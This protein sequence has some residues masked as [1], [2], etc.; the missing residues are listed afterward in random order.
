MGAMFTRGA[1][2]FALVLMMAGSASAAT[3]VAT[4]ADAGSSVSV[5]AGDTLLVKLRGSW[6]MASDLTP[7]LV[8]DSQSDTGKG[9]GARSSFTF[10]AD[11]AGSATLVV[12]N[13]ITKH[14]LSMV[15]DVMAPSP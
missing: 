11:S 12:R 9:A 1:A 15:V 7:E 5:T 8:L 6:A 3:V 10:S 4:T 13:K 2:A 14:E